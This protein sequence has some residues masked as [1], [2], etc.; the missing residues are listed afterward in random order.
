MIQRDDVEFAAEGGV[1]LRGWLFV[2]D[3]PAPH[4]AITMAHGA[5]TS[6]V[7]GL[8]RWRSVTPTP[9]R[10]RCCMC[11]RRVCWSP[12][13]SSTTVCTHGSHGVGM[14]GLPDSAGVTSGAFL[15]AEAGVATGA[16][17]AALAAA[18]TGRGASLAGDDRPSN[19]RSAMRG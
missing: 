19:T 6:K 7:F 11:P 12:A 16:R 8:F 10:R 18:V 13:M 3:G 5:W 14:G 1:T 2:P 17:R 4:P 15:F 9:K